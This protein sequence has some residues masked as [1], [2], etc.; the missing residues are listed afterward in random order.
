MDRKRCNALLSV[1]DVVRRAIGVSSAEVVCRFNHWQQQR[2]E[3]Y[4][5]DEENSTQT[6]WELRNLAVTGMKMMA[7]V[8]LQ[9]I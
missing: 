2:N 9:A 5:P 3:E 6:R 1:L 4:I 8:W 7:Q